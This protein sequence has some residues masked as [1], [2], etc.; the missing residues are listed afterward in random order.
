MRYYETMFIISSDYEKDKIS[1]LIESAE[2]EMKDNGANII[3]TDDWG[4]RKLAYRIDH[5]K[6][7][8]YVVIQV[9][10]DKEDYVDEIENWMKFT[11][12]ILVYM[13]IKL[14][15]KPVEKNK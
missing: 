9:E 2:K 7:G 3:N 13:T 5:E 10:T 15:E 12:G 1:Y 14:D 8:N 6:Y 4:K 11:E